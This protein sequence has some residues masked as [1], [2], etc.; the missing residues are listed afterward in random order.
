MKF[1]IEQAK[2]KNAIENQLYAIG[3]EI[4][5][6]LVKLFLFPTNEC[7]NH[8][9][10]KLYAFL[11]RISKVKTTKKYP[12]SRVIYSYLFGDMEDS[13]LEQV[14]SYI[15]VALLKDDLEY[16]S[17]DI[18]DNLKIKLFDFIR[19]YCKWISKELSTKGFITLQEVKNFIN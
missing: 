3:D 18:T 8:W 6:H 10:K 12:S 9:I 11:P 14:E 7:K 17:D 1:L 13:F 15:D 19:N 5:Y 2:N 16:N 4:V